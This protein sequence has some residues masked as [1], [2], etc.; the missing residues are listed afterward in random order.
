MGNEESFNLRDF[1]I[2]VDKMDLN[3]SELTHLVQDEN[4]TT[5]YK[6]NTSLSFLKE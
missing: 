2:N 4:E 1:N 3:T 6:L 5:Q